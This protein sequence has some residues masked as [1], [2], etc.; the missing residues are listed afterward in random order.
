MKFARLDALFRSTVLLELDQADL[1][2]RSH[3]KSVEQARE[4]LTGCMENSTPMALTWG[5]LGNT[6]APTDPA[7]A[8]DIGDVFSGSVFFDGQNATEGHSLATLDYYLRA[9]KRLIALDPKAQSCDPGSSPPRLFDAVRTRARL[10]ERYA[11]IGDFDVAERNLSCVVALVHGNWPKRAAE[12]AGL[13]PTILNAENE[14]QA[15]SRAREV[16]IERERAVRSGAE[17]QLEYSG[18]GGAAPYESADDAGF[19]RG[20][21]ICLPFAPSQYRELGRGTAASATPVSSETSGKR[22]AVGLQRFVWRFCIRWWSYSNS[23][24][25]VEHGG[26]MGRSF[27]STK[28]VRE[29]GAVCSC[30][31]RSTTCSLPPMSLPS[32]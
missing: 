6:F 21:D 9:W 2:V 14:L 31:N 7:V 17:G 28:S 8:L 20:D 25:E 11:D 3:I 30:S 27:S 23:L 1:Q 12:L 10:G 19:E 29:S 5:L 26:R 22:Q 32:A 24:A 16:G 13:I 18:I 15:Y 4:N